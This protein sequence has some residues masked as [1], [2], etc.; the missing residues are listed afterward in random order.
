MNFDDLV[1][2]VNNLKNI[3]GEVCL[4]C[5]LPIDMSIDNMCKL[6]CNHTYHDTCIKQLVKVNIITC[7]Y[8]QEQTTTINNCG[9]I[10]KTGKNKGN[11]YYC[12][13][14]D[15]N[16]HTKQVDVVCNTKQVDVVCNTKQVDVVCNTKQVDVVCNTKQVDVVCTI[17][18]KTG[19][20]KGK[21]CGRNK[22]KI[23]N[24]NINV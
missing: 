5:H 16:K 21:T 12:G 17:I 23:H 4:I 11:T 24:K 15:C 13:R 2:T 9:N 14:S 1:N 6:Y 7:P 18:L 20:N 8:C 10:I 3:K 19:I 22:C